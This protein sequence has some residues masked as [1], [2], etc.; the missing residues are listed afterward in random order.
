M[1]DSVEKITKSTSNTIRTH[2]G[3]GLAIFMDISDNKLKVKDV[4]GQTYDLEDLIDNYRKSS[5]SL[6]IHDLEVGTIS[7]EHIFSGTMT[8]L[9]VYFEVSG[10]GN[11]IINLNIRYGNT[12]GDAS[13]SLLLGH[14]VQ[15]ESGTRDFFEFQNQGII[16]GRSTIWLDIAEILSGTNIKLHMSLEYNLNR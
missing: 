8:L 9:K 2:E 7:F 13:G 5:K 4:R 1:N 3:N 10:N 14:T 12:E 15:I 11:P 16:P 6:T